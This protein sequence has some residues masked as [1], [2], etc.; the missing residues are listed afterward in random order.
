MESLNQFR[1]RH[2]LFTS[3]SQKIRMS[4]QK[5]WKLSIGECTS[6]YKGINSGMRPVQC[7]VEW[8]TM[9]CTVCYSTRNIHLPEDHKVREPDDIL[10]LKRWPLALACLF[11]IIIIFYI[12]THQPSLCPAPCPQERCCT[13]TTPPKLQVFL[14]IFQLPLSLFLQT[15]H[16]GS[17]PPVHNFL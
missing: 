1:D 17:L 3:Q 16:K 15:A 14:S 2:T 4:E 13:C 8:V 9:S 6:F 10:M 11:I 5:Q 12:G 7:Y